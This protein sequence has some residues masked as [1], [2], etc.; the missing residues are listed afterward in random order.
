MQ[1]CNLDDICIFWAR[2]NFRFHGQCEMHHNLALWYLAYVFD[3]DFKMCYNC[4]KVFK[5]KMPILELKRTVI[6]Q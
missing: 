2:L 4:K 3:F 1:K 5:Y 6:L